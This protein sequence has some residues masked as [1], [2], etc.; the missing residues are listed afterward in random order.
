MKTRSHHLAVCFVTFPHVLPF[1]LDS[2]IALS[3]SSRQATQ[4]SVW[5]L[6]KSQTVTT[7][8][9]MEIR[10]HHL[11]VCFVDFFHFPPF[12]LDSLIASL[13][14]GDAAIGALG[15]AAMPTAQSLHDFVGKEC[16]VHP[17]MALAFSTASLSSDTNDSEAAEM[18]ILKAHQ[19][20]NLRAPSSSTAN[21]VAASLPCKLGCNT[22]TYSTV[23]PALATN[24]GNIQSCSIPRLSQ[25]KARAKFMADSEYDSLYEVKNSL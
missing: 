16:S 7:Q 19:E 24:T 6:R 13:P 18:I 23:V 8:F 25:D 22:K 4:L 11:A 10:S 20:L 3:L 1:Y 2:L 12:Y 17:S 14:D 5:L 21:L 15:S 9:T